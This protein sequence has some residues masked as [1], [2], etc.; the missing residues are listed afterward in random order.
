[1]NIDSAAAALYAQA[2]QSTAA[3]PSRCTVPWGVC[4]DHGDTLTSRARATE[5]FDS[6]CTDVTRFNVW[7]YDRLDADCTEPATH[8]VQADN[9]DRYVVCDGHARTAR[10]QITDG[11]VL[12]G[13]PA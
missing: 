7:P 9:G 4:P 1:M 8:T 12:P 6:W 2:L 10:T 11:Q 5:G 3:D 13:L